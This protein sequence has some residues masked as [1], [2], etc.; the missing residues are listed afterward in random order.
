[1]KC[2]KC[3]YES[4]DIVICDNDCGTFYCMK[5]NA[6]FYYNDN[7][8]VVGHKGDCGKVIMEIQSFNEF[9]Q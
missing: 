6:E 3:G 9:S 5:C 8:L 4:K 2:V 1:M 7:K